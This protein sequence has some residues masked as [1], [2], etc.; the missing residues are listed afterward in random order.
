MQECSPTPLPQRTLP[1]Q[2][3]NRLC[4]CSLLSNS[5]DAAD[6]SNNPYSGIN[7]LFLCI[8]KKGCGG[9]DKNPQPEGIVHPSGKG[10]CVSS[11][12]GMCFF[13]FFAPEQRCVFL[14]ERRVSCVSCTGGTA[15]VPC[16]LL[17]AQNE[18]LAACF[19]PEAC[20]LFRRSFPGTCFLPSVIVYNYPVIQ[21]CSAFE[22]DSRHGLNLFE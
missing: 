6:G 15:P 16:F 1:I 5:S 7:R 4:E 13:V 10:R 20:F 8:R 14:A 18:A 22:S 12:F 2:T 19:L 3:T 17:A 21:A 9:R 11:D